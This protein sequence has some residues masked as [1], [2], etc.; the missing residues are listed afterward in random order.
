MDVETN[1][2]STGWA[3]R[4][5][6]SQITSARPPRISQEIVIP[7]TMRET[8]ARFATGVVVLTV[9]GDHIHG[10]TANA[11]SS[12]SLKP[13]LVL[14][15]VARTAVM[16]RAITS[17][18][19]FAFSVLR[20]DQEDRA[21]YFSSRARPLGSAQFDMVDWLPG[22]RTGAPLL[23]GSLAWLECEL[24]DA[25]EA[26]DHSVFIGHVLSSGRAASSPGLLFFDGAYRQVVPLE[27]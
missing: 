20:A 19:C 10:M 7:A 15:C 2:S 12:V 22:P 3:A 16:H 9:G 6:G 14:C 1:M 17:A 27:R 13:P 4:R 25:Y 23:S 5:A 18:G 24:A 26:G 8:M 11:F 21:R